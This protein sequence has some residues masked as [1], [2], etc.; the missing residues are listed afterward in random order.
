MV[1]YKTDA[2]PDRMLDHKV[3][4]LGDTVGGREPS[5]GVIDVE[6]STWAFIVDSH[7]DLRFPDNLLP[8]EYRRET[9]FYAGDIKSH[10][11]I[12]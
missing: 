12:G 1:F 9:L 11:K 5:L 4:S 6:R 7:A 3:T 8:V 10:I 2:V